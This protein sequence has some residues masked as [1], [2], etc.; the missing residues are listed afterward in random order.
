MEWALILLLKYKY[1]VLL[2]LAMFQ[3]SLT[4]LVSGFLVYQNLLNVWVAFGIILLGDFIPD[5]IFYYIGYHGQKNRIVKKYVLDNKFF[6][7]HLTVINKL[8]FDHGRKTMTLGKMSYGFAIPF[9]LSAGMAKMPY[10]KYILY[11]MTVSFFH[12][13]SIL[14]IGYI[15]GSSYT[16]A[17]EYINY[18]HYGLAGLAISLLIIYVFIMR[19]ARKKVIDLIKDEGKEVKL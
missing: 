10:R 9:L 18:L 2:P 17:D 4:S 14:I 19:Y 5:T 16:S 12:Y 7:N 6:S 11:A 1:F 8:W 13:G 15:L 3:G